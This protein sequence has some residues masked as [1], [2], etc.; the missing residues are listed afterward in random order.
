MVRHPGQTIDER[1][2]QIREEMARMMG[3]KTEANVRAILKDAYNHP[4]PSSANEVSFYTGDYSAPPISRFLAA[5]SYEAC[6]FSAGTGVCL[7]ADQ[8][9]HVVP[10]WHGGP[11]GPYL[12]KVAAVAIT[13]GQVEVEVL[14]RSPSDVTAGHHEA[15][16][17]GDLQPILKQVGKSATCS[18]HPKRLG[19]KCRYCGMWNHPAARFCGQIVDP[20]DQRHCGAPLDGPVEEITADEPEPTPPSDPRPTAA[21]I[22]EAI[23]MARGHTIY[24]MPPPPISTR[25]AWDSGIFRAWDTIKDCLEA[26]LDAIGDVMIPLL[27]AVASVAASLMEIEK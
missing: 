8:P 17:P 21:S 13:N 5:A 24:V 14:L 4:V 27:S 3:A 23:E 1:L 25:L 7:A 20:D 9:H 12:G 16:L 18:S 2:A 10:A 22:Q 15:Y 26:Q 11:V 6:D 19:I